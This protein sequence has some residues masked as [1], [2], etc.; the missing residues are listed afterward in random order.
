MS[1]RHVTKGCHVVSHLEIQGGQTLQSTQRCVACHI[2]SSVASSWLPRK[3]TG[4]ASKHLTHGSE[5]HRQHRRN[6]AMARRCQRFLMKGICLEIGASSDSTPCS[7]PP[8]MFLRIKLHRKRKKV[9][10]ARSNAA[11]GTVIYSASAAIVALR[12]QLPDGAT[13]SFSRRLQVCQYL[14]FAVHK[15]FQAKSGELLQF[16]E[17]RPVSAPEMGVLTCRQVKEAKRAGPERDIEGV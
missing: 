6:L 4:S 8:E 3:L 13:C 7:L 10:R 17:L 2:T 16:S 15:R 14:C 9:K 11:K 12:G 5:D 1:Q